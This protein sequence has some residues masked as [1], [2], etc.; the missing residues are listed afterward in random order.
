MRHY[1]R[2]IG[3]FVTH[4]TTQFSSR[5][6]QRPHHENQSTN[7][8]WSIFVGNISYETNEEELRSFF[9][10]ACNHVSTVRI[11]Y[12]N[13]TQQSRGFAFVQFDTLT[14]YDIALTL[15]GSSLN[16][17]KLRISPKKSRPKYFSI[18]SI[19]CCCNRTS[20]LQFDKEAKNSCCTL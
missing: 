1:K 3:R 16:G 20:T 14:A 2:S 5:S 18:N 8:I 11:I 9:D 6:E 19:F 4:M 7:S 13:Q 17:R 15:N 12:D 10:K